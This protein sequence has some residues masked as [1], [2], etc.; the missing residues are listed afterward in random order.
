MPKR[1]PTVRARSLGAELRDLRLATGLSTRAVA[2]RLG[3][4]AALVS[5][6]ENGKRNIP[7]EDVAALLVVYGI[8][9]AER[10]R[11]LTLAREADRPGWWETS[12]PGIPAQ[13]KALIGFESQAIRI[14]NFELVLIPGLLQTPEY[15]RAVMESAEVPTLLAE[16]RVAT[17]LGRQ[18]VL[19]RSDPPELLAIID[20]AA[21]R[22]P[23]G[24][25]EVMAQ[26]LD[27]IV[28]TAERTNV[29]VRVIPFDCGAHAAMTSSFV[30]LE[31]ARANAVVQLEAKR[32]VVLLD[33]P[34]DVSPFGTLADTL[35]NV[36]LAPGRSI[37][38]LTSIANEYEE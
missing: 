33:D 22:R 19:S 36:A 31:F 30:A 21:L 28:K 23:V 6:T 27:H 1:P 20:E 26:Q 29:T 24:G 35:Q 34:E 32:S 38:F 5:R 13:L 7:V 17:R 12:D 3:W 9:G 14:V 4:S 37:A 25:H 18:A 2:A 11:L 15:T 8:T 16:T 10:D